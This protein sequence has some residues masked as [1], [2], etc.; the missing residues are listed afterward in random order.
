MFR[1]FQISSAGGGGH[2]KTH[3]VIEQL[4]ALIIRLCQ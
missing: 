1:Q 2:Y 3:H 4:S